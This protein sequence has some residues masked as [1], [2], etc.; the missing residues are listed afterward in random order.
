LRIRT[1]FTN[2]ENTPK[3]VRI[4]TEN[5]MNRG[6]PMMLLELDSARPLPQ[7]KES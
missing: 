4:L 3:N 7:K 1:Y 5:E 6:E 2:I